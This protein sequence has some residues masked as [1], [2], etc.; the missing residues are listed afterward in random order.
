M[1]YIEDEKARV[2]LFLGSNTNRPAS[3]TSI[4]L[5]RGRVHTQDSGAFR[6]IG[7]IMRRLCRR[8]LEYV[9]N[10]AV[11]WIGCI[12]EVEIVEEIGS[13]VCIFEAVCELFVVWVRIVV[14]RSD[15]STDDDGYY[16]G[17]SRYSHSYDDFCSFRP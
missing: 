17:R 11:C 3:S 8:I 14:A 7:Q 13:T 16:D 15:Y 5:V 2:V 1:H 6:C 12:E 10:E 4:I 9:V